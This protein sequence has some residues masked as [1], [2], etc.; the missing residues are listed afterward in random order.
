MSKKS[1][2]QVAEIVEC[3]GL[4]YAIQ[5]FLDSK[6]IKDKFLADKWAEAKKLLDEIEVYLES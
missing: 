6:E 5:S 3:E 1:K 4:G 2:N